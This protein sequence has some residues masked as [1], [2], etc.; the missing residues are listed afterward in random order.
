MGGAGLMSKTRR[1][2]AN[3]FANWA[4]IA[5]NSIVLLFLMPYLRGVL[6]DERFGISLLATQVIHYVNLLAVS[7][8]PTTTRFV[9]REIAAGDVDGLNRTLS[10][11]LLF[12]VVIGTLGA[13]TGVA[14]G[15][16]LPGFYQVSPEYT[17]ETAI[18]FSVL[19]FTL[20]TQLSEHLYGSVL[21]GHHR[22]DLLN[23]GNVIRY[24]SRAGLIVAAFSVGF[25]SLSAVAFGTLGSHLLALVYYW[26]AGHRKEP[27]LRLNPRRAERGIA[28]EAASF[29]VSNTVIQVGN[30]AVFSTPSLIVGRVL[31]TDAVGYYQVPFLLADR[32]RMLVWGMATTLVPMAAATLVSGDRAEFRTL[33]V[34]GTRAAAMMCFPI[35]A[36]LLVLCKP[37]LILWMGE[38]YGSAWLVYGIVM[39]AMFGRIAQA[40]TLNILVGGGRIRGLACVQTISAVATIGLTILLCVVTDWGVLAAAVGITVPLFLSHSVFVPWYASRQM[41]MPLWRYLT[42]AYVR[43][44]LATLPGVAL[45]LVLT[46]IAP[47][48]GWAVW[49]GEFAA[50][51][52]L[53]GIAVW[54]TCVDQQMRERVMKKAGLR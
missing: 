48:T 9:A 54:F 5:S 40:P 46:R 18:L 11:M 52:A 44:A 19:G 34:K 45:A 8:R 14:L 42:E 32:I 27:G 39:I 29:G 4:G 12:F 51:L 31:G 37:F 35:G 25:R 41:E 49:I 23:V 22:Y 53:S 13:A 50:S 28:R 47:P 3:T 10:T 38:D 17:T 6:G 36:I 26:H 43:P 2:I 20:F 15:L 30:V 21:I 24:L 7:M 16:L 1:V 33:I